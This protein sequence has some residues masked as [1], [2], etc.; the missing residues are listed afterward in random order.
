M[1]GVLTPAQVGFTDMGSSLKLL[2]L[3]C[4]RLCGSKISMPTK[5]GQGIGNANINVPSGI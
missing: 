5:V 2:V 1:G 3:G 4:L